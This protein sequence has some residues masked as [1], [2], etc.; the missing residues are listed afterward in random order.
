[1]FQEEKVYLIKGVLERHGFPVEMK[2]YAEIDALET[3]ENLLSFKKLTP[4]DC[5][6]FRVSQMNSSSWKFV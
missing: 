6:F 2:Y 3:E 4:N 5:G 1:M